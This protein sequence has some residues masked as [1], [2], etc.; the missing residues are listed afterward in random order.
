MPA[1]LFFAGSQQKSSSQSVK[2]LASLSR[3]TGAPLVVHFGD[4]EWGLLPGPVARSARE[5]LELAARR[6]LGRAHPWVWPY[7]TPG[8]LRFA[9]HSAD[10]FDARPG[11]AGHRMVALVVAMRAATVSQP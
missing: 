7:S 6:I 3:A 8:W 10:A 4:D 5:R 9:G 11:L 2:P 1:L